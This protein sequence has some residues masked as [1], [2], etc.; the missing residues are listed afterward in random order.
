MRL[1]CALRSARV[2]LQVSYGSCTVRSCVGLCVEGLL[3]RTHAE[4]NPGRRRVGIGEV[5]FK[6]VL[7][8]WGA[9]GRVH[10]PEG[11]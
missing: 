9:R 1:V 11:R 7:G 3:L 5:L 8:A 2:L 4:P 10:P 6:G